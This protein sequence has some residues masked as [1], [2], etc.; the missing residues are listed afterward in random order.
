MTDFRLFLPD[1]GG[2][3]GSVDQNGVL[4]FVVA[5][6][7]GCPIRGTEMFDLMMRAFGSRVRAINGV[8]RRGFAGRPSTNFDKVNELARAGMPL[9]AAVKQAWTAT[10]AARW[11]F[12]KVS[13]LA[14]TEG[15]PGNY[16][17]IDVLIERAEGLP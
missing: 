13:V 3:I 12:T 9:E 14:S 5:A 11:N 4:S 2:I 15:S 10:R 6:G 16:V 7:E 8:W 1:D 17:R